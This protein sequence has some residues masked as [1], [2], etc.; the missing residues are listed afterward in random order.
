MQLIVS[1]IGGEVEQPH[2]GSERVHQFV[3][4]FFLAGFCGSLGYTH[5]PWIFREFSSVRSK[6]RHEWKPCGVLFF[7]FLSDVS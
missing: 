3:V 2:M 4:N 7:P 5:P 1:K 6:M